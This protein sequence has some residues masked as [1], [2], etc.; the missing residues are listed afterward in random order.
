[1]DAATSAPTFLSLLLLL[2]SRDA[3]DGSEAAG[4]SDGAAGSSRQRSTRSSRAAARQQQRKAQQLSVVLDEEE[5]QPVPDWAEDRAEGLHQRH[6]GTQQQQQDDKDD[7]QPLL[8][9]Q[10]QAGGALTNSSSDSTS[11]ML[12][13]AAGKGAGTQGL[14]SKYG[15]D[16]ASLAE[17]YGVSVSALEDVLHN[18]KKA[19]AAAEERLKAAAHEAEERLLGTWVCESF[20]IGWERGVD[21]GRTPAQS[22]LVAGY[23]HRRQTTQHSQVAGINT[24]SFLLHCHRRLVSAH[25]LALFLCSWHTPFHRPLFPTLLCLLHPHTPHTLPHPHSRD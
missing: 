24:R 12:A 23:Q 2:C 4:A 21:T 22:G 14:F 17:K 20:L 16:L 6:K 11:S 18:P 5:G 1:V 15:V 3:A 25:T 19:A 8:G 13:P 7:R 10:Q 9:Q